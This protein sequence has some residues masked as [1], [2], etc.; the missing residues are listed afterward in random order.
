[1]GQHVGVF[2]NIRLREPGVDNNNNGSSYLRTRASTQNDV[3]LLFANS[4][5]NSNGLF[6]K[7]TS[8]TH[9]TFGKEEVHHV[10]SKCY[11]SSRTLLLL[12]FCEL[13]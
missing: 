4:N 3:T 13:E 7:Q 11:Y 8:F 10:Y 2:Q 1:M 6:F 5:S 12:F 9:A